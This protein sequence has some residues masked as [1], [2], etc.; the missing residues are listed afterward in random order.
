MA[1]RNSWNATD[2]IP[3]RA[4][5]SGQRMQP[6]DIDQDVA[7]REAQLDARVCLTPFIMREKGP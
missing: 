2:Q 7:V 4:V 1:Y 3:L 5:Q 6:L